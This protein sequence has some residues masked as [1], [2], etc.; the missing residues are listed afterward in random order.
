MTTMNEYLMRLEKS[1][2]HMSVAEKKDILQD[3]REH[4]E[5]GKSSGKTEEQI[6]KALG[7]PEQLAKMFS[8]VGAAGRAHESRGFRA[9]LRMIG[10][11]LSFKVGGGILAA[12]L[13]FAC[14]SVIVSLYAGATGV[15]LAGAG[16]LAVMAIEII[17]GYPMWAITA[18]FA[19]MMLISGGLL[20]CKGLAWVWRKLFG[21]LPLLVKRMMEKAGKKAIA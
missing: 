11:F 7:E 12:V 18:F 9:S 17:K 2:K 19:A 15:V 10:A 5:I 14:L 13:Y 3:Y 8:A 1:L 20:C 16:S 21:A 4:F 6:A